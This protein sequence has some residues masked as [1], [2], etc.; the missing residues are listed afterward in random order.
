MCKAEGVD[1]ALPPAPPAPEVSPTWQQIEKR[2]TERVQASGYRLT[3][4]QAVV[5]VLEADPTL[6]RQ[7]KAETHGR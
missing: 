1:T 6:Y 2:A 5:Q 4:Q 3:K 7:Y